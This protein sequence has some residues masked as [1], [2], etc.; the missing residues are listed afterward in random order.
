MALPLFDQILG[1]I[2]DSLPA[3]WGNPLLSSGCHGNMVRETGDQTTGW[4][5]DYGKYFKVVTG[6]NT[7]K[8]ALWAALLV[9]AVVA[10]IAVLGSGLS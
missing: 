3:N 2:Q 1:Q 4:V 5:M 8:L 7:Q 9:L 10:G 6:I